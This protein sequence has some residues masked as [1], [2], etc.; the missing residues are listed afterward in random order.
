MMRKALFLTGLRVIAYRNAMISD[1]HGSGN[2]N[3][4]EAQSIYDFTAKD[5]DGNQVS[6]DKYRGHFASQEPG[7]NSEIKEFAASYNVKF[8]M[9]AKI[10]V[11]GDNAHPLWKYL[12]LK[13]GGTLFDAIKWNFTK[14]IVDKNGQP[15]ARHAT[16]TIPFD[17]EKD[18]LK[19][20]N[21]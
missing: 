10:D 6:L 20:L 11:N 2:A 7:T 19:Y 4:K 5:I 12:K 21:Q 8:D 16:T 13:Q 9:F 3:Y 14:F 18:L 1:L 15:V 17:M